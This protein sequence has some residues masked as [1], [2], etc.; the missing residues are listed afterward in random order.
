MSHYDAVI[1]G[2]GKAG[3]TLAPQI[4]ARGRKVAI[5]EKSPL[6]YGGTCPNVGCIPSKALITR[7]KEINL[8][9]TDWEMRRQAYRRAIQDK[10]EL[11]AALR[12][13]MYNKLTEAGV[14]IIDGTGSFIDNKTLN[15]TTANGGRQ[16]TSDKFFINTGAVSLIP[17]IKGI[18]SPRVYTSET[19]MNL[20]NLPQT[21]V[22]IGGGYIGLEFASM[23][24]NFGSKVVV[25]QDLPDFL[26][27]ED[28]DIA[29]AIL[30]RLKTQGV[31]FHFGVKVEELADLE[32]KIE[33]KYQNQSQS[34]RLK[35]DAVLV[36]TGRRPATRELNAAKAGIELMPNGAVKVNTRLQT[37]NPIIW[38]M[39]DVNGGLQF[40]YI[41]LDDSRIVRSQLPI[42]GSDYTTADRK[43]IPYSVFIDPT[44]SRVG[45]NEKEATAQNRKIKIAKLP[46]A[47]I[48]RAKA[49]G[50]TDGLLKAVIDAET[51]QILGMML[52]CAESYEVINLVKL[53]MDQQIP[54]TVLRD[55]IYTHPSMSEALNDLLNV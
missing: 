54:Y 19:L 36:A 53:A 32:D 45:M 49:I 43:N 5:V 1:I 23:Y 55:M 47:A 16:I 37:T 39:G 41:S 3:K 28:D 22:I 15:V 10:N 42:G 25:L 21:L 17:P 38:A 13:N 31:E 6:M 34:F 9:P 44:Y 2:F 18:D 35:A 14:E 24:A 52:F 27:R 4:A 12:S 20:S 48:P 33:V 11:T 26:P 8:L 40:T 46:A 30:G 51:S 50:E 7:A 29:K